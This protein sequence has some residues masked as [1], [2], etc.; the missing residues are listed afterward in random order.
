MFSLDLPKT[1]K[2]ND[3][4]TIDI[5][6]DKEGESARPWAKEL[7]NALCEFLDEFVAN[8]PAPINVTIDVGPLT[9]NPT[10]DA[11]A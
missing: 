5:E 7:R 11:E 8:N 4:I 6:P 3:Q 2:H 9:Y 10:Q 1:M